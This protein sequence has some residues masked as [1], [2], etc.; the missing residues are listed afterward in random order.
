MMSKYSYSRLLVICFLFLIPCITQAQKKPVASDTCILKLNLPKGAK[1]TIEGQ[2]YGHQ[3]SLNYDSLTPGNIYNSEVKVRFVNGESQQKTV[4]IQGGRS[5][6]LT[7]Q[8]P[9]LL[10]PELI[11]QTGGIY[12]QF[13]EF[14]K[15]N[16]YM[17]TG[18]SN[19]LSFLREIHG[20]LILRNYTSLTNHLTGIALT[21]DGQQLIMGDDEFVVVRDLVFGKLIRKWKSGRISSL[22]IH[23]QGNILA[24]G[25]YQK[26][27]LWD[28]KSGEKLK[29]LSGDLKG[30]IYSVVFSSDGRMMA[31]HDYDGQNILWDITTGQVLHRF[32]SIKKDFSRI[33]FS[34]DNKYL[35][36]SNNLNADSQNSF[37][38]EIRL[39]DVLSGEQT[40]S[41]T[42]KSDIYGIAY[43]P[44]GKLIGVRTS[45]YHS[46]NNWI[47]NILLLDVKSLQTIK[48][49]TDQNMGGVIL[50]SP[51]GKSIFDGR[52]L[53]DLSTSKK[54]SKLG[55]HI[56]K[57]RYAI[58]YQNSPQIAFCNFSPKSN[59]ELINTNSFVKIRDFEL[60][61]N[62]Y[63]YTHA[64]ISK[65][66]RHLAAI[67][68]T[69]EKDACNLVDFDAQTGKI[70]KQFRVSAN[71]VNRF[72][73]S[74]DASRAL[75]CT[76]GKAMVWD[77]RRGISL[78][79]FQF[80]V[81]NIY[82]C[83]LSHDGR[84]ILTE[85]DKPFVSDPQTGK[86]IRNVA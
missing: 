66:E 83:D 34:P 12:T 22:A 26:I 24:T 50:F 71:T 49:F 60:P 46:E 48:T 69:G 1:A 31:C 64:A 23:P 67:F 55:D 19:G 3:D 72:S 43:S 27:S 7:V 45:S 75:I 30:H 47:R 51:D 41:R 11:T 2:E 4:L 73:I 54:D 56:E 10:K 8:D 15:N 35:I 5:I 82:Y 9:L 6:T 53:W 40:L 28:P 65:D 36:I 13:A 32:D 29:D 39:Y 25:Q 37:R 33:A 81:S 68:K 59:F 57:V 70:L 63:Y 44:D 77:L 14:H 74:S 42:V 79:T 16:Q 52:N 20:G 61:V 76:D 21:P 86:L 18:D 38:A 84:R 78:R 85:A 17:V 62:L 58:Y 80:E